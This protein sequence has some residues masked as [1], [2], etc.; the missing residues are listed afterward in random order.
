MDELAVKLEKKLKNIY[1]NNNFIIAVLSYAD[2]NDK[3][4]SV[5]DFIDNDDSE[6]NDE[7]V[8]VYAMELND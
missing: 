2:D 5:I 4:Q 1:D 7:T 3:R 6:V 8:L